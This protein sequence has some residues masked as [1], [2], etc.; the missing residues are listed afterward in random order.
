VRRPRCG[1]VP[2]R[3]LNS[4]TGEPRAA[5]GGT[6]RGRAIDTRRDARRGFFA[7]AQSRRYTPLPQRE[8]AFALAPRFMA[9]KLATAAET[10]LG[11]ER[12]RSGEE[13]VLTRQWPQHP[14][15]RPC[16]PAG[17]LPAVGHELPPALFGRQPLLGYG[18]WYS[19]G[20]AREARHETSAP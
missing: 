12:T 16:R 11:P 9:G 5:R 17:T 3:R 4:R 1:V 19:F 10:W 14:N 13:A 15:K 2:L 20:A 6:N 7:I 18:N 8:R